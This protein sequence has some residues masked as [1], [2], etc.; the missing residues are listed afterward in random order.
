M[1]NQQ[2]GIRSNMLQQDLA[3]LDPFLIEIRGS[4]GQWTISK[5][6]KI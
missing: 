2:A 4:V 1:S 6:R 3:S 5:S